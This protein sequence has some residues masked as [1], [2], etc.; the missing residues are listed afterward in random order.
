[1]LRSSSPFQACGGAERNLVELSDLALRQRQ[2]L[3]SEA[4]RRKSLA[5][6]QKAWMQEVRNALLQTDSD[7][8]SRLT[9][10]LTQLGERTLSE[11]E[12]VERRFQKLAVESVERERAAEEALAKK[13]GTRAVCCARSG[14]T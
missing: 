5:D 10:L 12:A 14:N 4:D 9:T 1:M 11:R 6:D 3:D 13:D 8:S 7:M 2:Q